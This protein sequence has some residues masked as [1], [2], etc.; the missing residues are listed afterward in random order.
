LVEV[1][2]L[3]YDGM[4][5]FNHVVSNPGTSSVLLPAIDFQARGISASNDITSQEVSC[6]RLDTWARRREVSPDLLW[7]DVQG[8]ELQV[9]KGLGDGLAKVSAVFV[10]AATKEIYRGQALKD[11]IVAFL[12]EHGF[13]LVWEQKYWEMES[14]YIFVNSHFPHCGFPCYRE[15]LATVCHPQDGS[16]QAEDFYRNSREKCEMVRRFKPNKIVEIGVRL[17]YS[18]HAFLCAMPRASY[19][20]F[21]IVGG[22]HGGTDIAGLEYPDQILK[23]DFPEATIRLVKQNTQETKDL[24]LA[25]VDFF[26]VDG[27][28]SFEGASHDMALAWKAL[29]SGGVMV[30]DDYDFLPRVRKAVDIFLANHRAEMMNHE[31]IKSFRGDVIMVK[32]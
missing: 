14:Y 3:D 15:W 23:R 5:R 13:R 22:R 32:K 26:H 7:I 28:H 11:E 25:D 4:V 9:L 6:L 12:T 24:G 18:A 17:G 21:D 16:C 27:D 30:V 29:R 2:I 8:A 19:T 1:A 20:G 31:Y 10:E